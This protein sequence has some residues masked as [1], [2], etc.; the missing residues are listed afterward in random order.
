MRILLLGEYSNLHNTLA[1]GLRELGHE[2]VLAN[3]GDFWKGYDRDIDL[4]HDL[5]KMGAL[6]FGWRLL[7]ALPR[8]RGFDI[9][10][11][12]NPVFLE[13]KAE[14]IPPFFDYLQKH[15]R[16]IVMLAAGDDYYSVHTHSM[17][18]PMRYSDYNRGQEDWC[19]PLGREVQKAWTVMPKGELTRYVASRVDSIVGC[20][21]EYWIAYSLTQDSDVYGHPLKDKLVSIPFPCRIEERKVKPGHD[22]LNVF[23]GISRERSEFKGTDVMLRAAQDLQEMYPDRMKLQVAEGVPFDQ[24]Q[25]ML[26]Q[27]DVMLDQL[28]SYGPGM[29]ALLA[30]SRGVITLSG[31]E[32]EHYGLLGETDCQPIV[33]VEPTYQSVYDQLQN[34]ILNPGIVDDLKRQSREYVRRNH[35]YK[36]VATEYARLYDSLLG[37]V[38]R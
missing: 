17:V 6:S 21:Y 10:Q 1:R 38:I 30:M 25:Q 28:Y 35:D 8:M 7:K 2:V 32:P 3:N 14:R 36:K 20:A 27:A 15:N 31:G 13:L 22:R 19:T 34:L 9:V 11:L 12:I 18:K 24:Y 16:K 33:N 26:D 5:T 23:V 37:Q 4:R 29:N